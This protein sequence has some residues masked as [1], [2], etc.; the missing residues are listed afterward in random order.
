MTRLK[1]GYPGRVLLLLLA[2]W[3]LELLP[4]THILQ[5]FWMYPLPGGSLASAVATIGNAILT[6]WHSYPAVPQVNRSYWTPESVKNAL[7]DAYLWTHILWAGGSLLW[8]SY[9][10]LRLGARRPSEREQQQLQTALH[11]LTRARNDIAIPRRWLVADGPGLRLRWIGYVLIVDRALLQHRHLRALLA[12]ELGHV[13]QEDRMARRLYAMLPTPRLTIFAVLGLPVGIG[14]LALY[15]LWAAYWRMRI[16][17][18]DRYAV[19][20]NQGYALSKALNDLYL[21][22]DRITKFGRFLKAIPY[23][24]TRI[25]RIEKAQ[26]QYALARVI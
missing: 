10:R 6:Y 9:E 13:N 5:I 20:L 3:T 15:P 14:R 16:Y 12:H 11:S 22:L 8:P 7:T 19:S 4:G 23:I 24:E 2:S 1:R 17:A 26:A 18:A 25:G 21:P